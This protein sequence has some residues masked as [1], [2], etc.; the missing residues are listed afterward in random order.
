MRNSFTSSSTSSYLSP[1]KLGKTTQSPTNVPCS[2]NGII[3]L[4]CKSL[5][6][7]IDP[8]F[9]AST[10]ST[11][12]PNTT[13]PTN[14][15]VTSSISNVLGASNVSTVPN[16]SLLSSSSTAVGT[17]PTTPF[18]LPPS[19]IPVFK[20]KLKRP[21]TITT[22]S[23]ASSLS[24][25]G[26][27]KTSTRS[28]SG[29][30]P[31]RQNGSTSS[32]P[33]TGTLG[34]I[35][36]SVSVSFIQLLPVAAAVESETHN[37]VR[38]LLGGQMLPITTA[39]ADAASSTTTT[40]TTTT[41]SSCVKPLPAS[42]SS[43][44]SHNKINNGHRDQQTNNSSS[45]H[46]PIPP[47]FPQVSV[48]GLTQI[49]VQTYSQLSDLLDPLFST[50][51]PPELT[52][53]SPTILTLTVSPKKQLSST[54]PCPKPAK[55]VFV[56]TNGSWNHD[57][58]TLG[59]VLGKLS[60]HVHF[61]Q[62]H[63]QQNSSDNEL[64]Q[65]R[66]LN[67]PKLPKIP[68]S[69][70]ILTNLLQESLF[71][72]PVLLISTISLSSVKNIQ[73]VVDALEYA[74]LANP[75]KSSKT[76]NSIASSCSSITSSSSSISSSSSNSTLTAI[77][78]NNRVLDLSLDPTTPCSSPAKPLQND[79][80]SKISEL[81]NELSYYKKIATETTD[82]ISPTVIQTSTP[83]TPLNQSQISRK[84]PSRHTPQDSL[85]SVTSSI[86][87]SSSSSLSSSLASSS[88]LL[89]GSSSNSSN[90]SFRNS[91]QLDQKI[92][93]PNSSFSS[94]SLFNSSNHAHSNSVSGITL[95]RASRPLS[96]AS[97]GTTDDGIMSSIDT[98]MSSS[99]TTTS[100]FS[101][102]AEAY[103]NSDYEKNDK[104]LRSRSISNNSQPDF[105]IEKLENFNLENN[106]DS[107][108][109]SD[110]ISNQNHNHT[111]QLQQ[112]HNNNNH[113]NHNHNNTNTNT[114]NTS[115]VR[116]GS[117][118][119]SVLNDY[120]KTIVSLQ[121]RIADLRTEN[122]RLQDECDENNKEMREMHAI[123]D[124]L[125]QIVKQYDGH[126]IS[127]L[128]PNK[129]SSTEKKVNNK[130]QN[131]DEDENGTENKN[132]NKNKNK[133]EGSR[134]E[135]NEEMEKFI[136]QNKKEESTIVRELKIKLENTE[137]QYEAAQQELNILRMAQKRHAS[138]AQFLTSR[139]NQARKDV[140]TLGEENVRLTEA[141]EKYQ[142][143]KNGKN[144][145]TNDNNND[146]DD[147]DGI[148]T[149]IKQP[150]I[151]DINNDNKNK[152]I[153]S[154]SK[155]SKT[156]SSLRSS[157]SLK[158]NYIENENE[159]E[160]K[161]AEEEEE[162]KELSKRKSRPRP[163]PRP[164]S[165][166]DIFQQYR[167]ITLKKRMYNSDNDDDNNNN[168]N[169]DGDGDEFYK[170]SSSSHHHNNINNNNKDIINSQNDILI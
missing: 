52:Q 165:S 98:S 89:N 146:N 42:S 56:C 133:T 65:N 92:T 126:V 166:I 150:I 3:K 170:E 149:T 130:A 134:V 27:I 31:L 69:D 45:S 167:P 43:T 137:K 5:F 86:S 32:A 15:A 7:H 102:I 57:I 54:T 10:A 13:N 44:S 139:Y 158:E 25:K 47:S 157:S 138:D 61:Q 63:Q 75:Y 109:D 129:G 162:S 99:S 164:F 40:T 135:N 96:F 123:N 159:N 49:P 33:S 91:Q 108:D 4:A 16:S 79:L 112:T 36:W 60:E 46:R 104:P 151:D 34:G 132:E 87:S 127:L 22:P 74:H 53:D 76:I 62:Q 59:N 88:P 161:E 118:L 81:Q 124:E 90:S 103:G 94:S 153:L 110:K 20:S 141:L 18:G 39:P 55:I 70:S 9:N 78:T 68:F 77:S 111:H 82:K 107:H 95:R 35:P 105:L 1:S 148:K 41:N 24:R 11:T 26:S 28:V 23:S 84:T 131:E 71:S 64:T 120:E 38:D 50:P 155:N 48:S 119:E 152:N 30:Q 83:Q 122:M 100:C 80:I 143:G 72:S 67:N 12:T 160:N 116:R 128:D 114:H 140:E 6:S 58:S 93:T 8:T 154:I 37:C 115:S 101:S 85:S 145:I 113:Y 51:Q 106:I 19:A 125:L 169:E 73:N 147:G 17:T 29:Q 136:I 97:D 121:K 163:R 168:N 117:V 14:P 2:E 66:Y 21:S 144:F 156:L 142:E